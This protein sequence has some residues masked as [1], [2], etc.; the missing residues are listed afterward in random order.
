MNKFVKVFAK[1]RVVKRGYEVCKEV[2]VALE[3]CGSIGRDSLD[4]RIKRKGLVIKSAT[5]TERV[6]M[7]DQLT[8]IIVA[9]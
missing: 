6:K 5:S 7:A 8:R 1:N 2:Y 3:E 9:A 4:G